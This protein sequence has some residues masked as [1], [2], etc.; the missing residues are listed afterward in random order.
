MKMRFPPGQQQQFLDRVKQKSGFSVVHLAEQLRVHPRTVRDWQRGKY[1][2]SDD[3][4]ARLSELSGVALPENVRAIPHYWYVTHAGQLGGKRRY[5]LHGPLGTPESRRQG[6]LKSAAAAALHPDL[7]RGAGF[8]TRKAIRIPE[9][10]EPL[11]EF[12][13]IMLGDGGV[14]SRWQAAI[15]FNGRED[16]AHAAWICQ[17]IQE[18]FSIT[19]FYSFGKQ[20]GAADLVMSSVALVEFLVSCGVPNGHKIR[21]GVAIPAW[22]V[23]NLSYR[24]AC[25]RGLM[26]TDGSVYPHRYRVNGVHYQYPKMCFASASPPL[27]QGVR[28]ILR[29]DGYHPRIN[30]N[31]RCVYLERQED[32]DRYFAEIGTHNPRYQRRY[33]RFKAI[34]GKEARGEVP[35]WLTGIA[36]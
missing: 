10:S 26:D 30:R 9:R 28:E 16:H 34:R 20:P 32:V 19:P 21:N 33:E 2:M 24:R 1:L 13:G 35:K 7:R 23:E 15:S 17:L 12:L 4:A 25:V 18:L 29:G 22:I 3:T 14:R 8:Q 6:G 27:L 11:A 31:G 5:E 36:C